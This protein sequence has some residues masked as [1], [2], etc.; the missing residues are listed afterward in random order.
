MGLLQAKM[1]VR[2]S[3]EITFTLFACALTPKR[4]PPDMCRWGIADYLITAD[5]LKTRHVAAVLR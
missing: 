1:W 5:K 4:L 3:L 2:A